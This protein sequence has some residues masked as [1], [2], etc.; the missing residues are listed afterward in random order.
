MHNFDYY[1]GME[2]EQFSFFRIPRLLIKDK[3][4][5]NLSSDAKILYGLMLDR[6]A[7][8]MK[9]EWLD[10]Y[11]RVYI[12]YTTEEIADDLGCSKPTCTKIIKELDSQNGIGLIEKVRQGRGK[13][14]IIYVKNF[15]VL[16]EAS[17]EKM[18]PTEKN[19]CEKPDDIS[20]SNLEIKNFNVKK[21]K[22]L[23]SRNQNFLS[24]EIKNFN[25]NY[26]NKSYTDN[27]YTN[28]SINQERKGD[29]WTDSKA[30]TVDNYREM[31]KANISY[32]DLIV[33]DPNNKDLY[34]ELYAL[35]CEVVCVRR[36]NIRIAGENYPYEL[37]KANFLKLNSSHMQYVIECLQKNTEKIKNIKAYMLT[38]LF[39]AASTMNNYYQ[40]EIQ[41]DMYG[42]L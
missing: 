4:F 30:T 34:D 18:C 25:P 36:Q 32:D 33:I 15:T 12:I 3:R 38:V 22:N 6:M 9:N 40:Q 10:E 19:K 24:L 17:S 7:L 26:T 11:D 14:D 2:A 39:N 42:K 31:I 23:T 28:L 16:E 29:G 21:S 27:S 35:L 20:A 13:P 8:S 37:V 5:K 41:H 1:Y